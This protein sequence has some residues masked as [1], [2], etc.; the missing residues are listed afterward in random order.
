MRIKIIRKD[1]LVRQTLFYT[2]NMWP[3]DYMSGQ[4][5]RPKRRPKQAENMNS[6]FNNRLDE[7]MLSI[8]NFAWNSPIS[9]GPEHVRV[10]FTHVY[11]LI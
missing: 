8:A 4:V 2:R 5:A 11:F 1:T 6:N 9:E 3:S 10:Y 7:N